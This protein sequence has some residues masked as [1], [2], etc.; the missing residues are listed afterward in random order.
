MARYRTVVQ[1]DDHMKT[2]DDGTKVG[3]WSVHLSWITHSAAKITAI[4]T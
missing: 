1:V 2:V 4:Q 3:R